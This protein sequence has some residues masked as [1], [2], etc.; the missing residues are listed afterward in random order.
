MTVSSGAT[1][2]ARPTAS[3][4]A[5]HSSSAL[6]TVLQNRLTG[7]LVSGRLKLDLTE[8]LDGGDATRGDRDKKAARSAKVEAKR[9]NRKEAAAASGSKDDG[10]GGVDGG[11]DFLDFGVGGSGGDGESSKWKWKP[12]KV[13][14]WTVTV[15]PPHCLCP[16]ARSH[17]LPAAAALPLLTILAGRV[18]VCLS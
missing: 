7:L 15:S 11:W 3:S 10:W 8:L 13:G 14:I 1:V 17:R 5:S 6:I 9:Q 18:C 4:T 16:S 2:R 12:A